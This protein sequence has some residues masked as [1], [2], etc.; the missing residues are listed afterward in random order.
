I[1]SASHDGYKSQFG[2]THYRKFQF[3][4]NKVMVTDSLSGSAAGQAFASF[5]L[6]PDV[7]LS[8][9]EDHIVLNDHILIRFDGAN[10]V[11]QETYQHA[12]GFNHTLPA[13][14]LRI[15]FTSHLQTTIDFKL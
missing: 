15:A 5:H 7:F 9:Q 14:V 6:H 10:R 4:S 8:V 3:E 2:I 12:V 1:L 13:T 11:A